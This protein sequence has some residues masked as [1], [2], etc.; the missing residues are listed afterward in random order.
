MND[1]LELLASL[2]NAAL[3]M[4]MQPFYYIALLFIAFY[5]RRQTLLE[6]KLIHVK[7]HSWGSE[8][9]RAVWSG[10]AAGVLVSAAAVLLGVSVTGA[11][12]VCIWVVS[13]VLVIFRVRYFCFAYSIG[14]LGILQFILSFFPDFQPGGLGGEA[15]AAIRGMDIPALLALAA[16]LHLA[17]A[18]LARWQGPALATPLFLEGK[19]GRVVGGYRMEAFWP[20]PLFLLVPA[21]AGA[22]DLPWQTLLGG[23]FGLVS[24]PV[25]IG[26]SQLTTGMLPQRKAARA[27]GWLLLY[28]AVLLGLALAAAWYSPLT[29]PAA[30]AA[31]LLHEGLVWYGALEERRRSPYFVHPPHGLK[32]LAVLPGSPAHELGILPGEVLL[33]V[34]GEALTG[35]ALQLHEALR[36]SPAFCKLEV[37]NAAGES[38]YLQRAIYDGDHHLLGV[39]LAPQPDE[40]TTAPE[41][42]AGI[43]GI[44]LMKTGARRRQSGGSE[45][46]PREAAAA[47]ETAAAPAPAPGAAGVLPGPGGAESAK[48]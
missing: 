12:V 8:V 27:S 43:L 31:L 34:N 36:R 35:R 42:P 38:K 25:I 10:L 47:Q 18:L 20:L 4:L 37:Q 39:I 7:M 44:A 5:Y 15:A 6:R 40:D 30:L 32:V 41:K 2:G 16:I 3:H 9:W 28:G 48:G 1:M 45:L 13:A 24:L 26:F 29:L 11:A 33:K 14:L 17:E 21:G 23:G 19:R 22:G 46:L